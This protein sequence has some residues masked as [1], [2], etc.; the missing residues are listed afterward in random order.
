MHWFL[1]RLFLKS[2]WRRSKCACFLAVCVATPGLLM[3]ARTGEGQTTNAKA[4][5][6][7][8]SGKLIFAREG[9]DKCHGSEGEGGATPG[10]NEGVPRIASTS[11][12]LPTFIRRVRK[13]LGQ[14]PA[15]STQRVSDSELSEVYTFLQAAQSPRESEKSI[16][17]SSRNGQRL[18]LSYGC[19]E[20][21]G[22]VGQGSTQTG[23]SRLGPPQIP[24]SAF[25][26]YVRQPTGQMPP[27]TTRTVSDQELRDMYAF[28]KSLPQAT[29]SRDISILNQ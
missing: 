9:C 26:D 11:L 25:L 17:S 15:F 19:Y 21:H 16:P 22:T 8:P 5:A 24:F 27:Y 20:C 4:S 28:L 2:T 14:M 23:G 7:A 1:D 3:M 10:R 6:N 29:P 13:P 12:A 18:F